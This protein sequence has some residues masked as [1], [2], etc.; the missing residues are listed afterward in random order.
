MGVHTYQCPTCKSQVK[1]RAEAGEK[2]EVGDCQ[3]CAEE[4]RIAGLED[5]ELEEEVRAAL[6]GEEVD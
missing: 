6:N 3:A 2:V 1:V 5:H 4:K